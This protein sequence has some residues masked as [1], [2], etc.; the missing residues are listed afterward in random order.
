MVKVFPQAK[1]WINS[2][3]GLAEVNEHDNLKHGVGIQMSQV[4]RIEV[5]ETTEKGINWQTQPSD[6]EGHENDRFVGVLCRDDN[7][8]PDQPRA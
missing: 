8:P 6:L 3:E 1:V 2:Q 7:P 5:N 4:E